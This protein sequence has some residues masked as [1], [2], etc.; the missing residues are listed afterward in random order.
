MGSPPPSRSFRVNP[1]YFSSN[2]TPADGENGEEEMGEFRLP[3][4]VGTTTHPTLSA[5]T[6]TT[7]QGDEVED[8]DAL[9][10]E[11]EAA[12]EESAREEEARSRQYSQPTASRQYVPSDD[13]SEVS[14]EE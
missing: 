13:E 3:S 14:E 7:T 5:P 10:A 12:F 8:D 4:P 6:G 2:N 9:A 1:A 11:M